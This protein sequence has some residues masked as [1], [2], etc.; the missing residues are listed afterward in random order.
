M[1]YWISCAHYWEL[2]LKKKKKKVTFKTLLPTDNVLVIICSGHPKAL[3]EIWYNSCCFHAYYHNN[4]FV[5]HESGVIFTFISYS[6]KDT[7]CKAIAATVSDSSYGSGQTKLKTFW[8]RFTILDPI[9]DSS[10]KKLIPTFT[11]DSEGFKTSVQDVTADVVETAKEPA[12]EVVPE[13]V[14]ELLK[15]HEKTWMDE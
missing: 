1:V 15:S 12:L 4:H 2:L 14:T 10:W 5:A 13:D 11:D 3:M 8:K 9:H 7:F 6:L